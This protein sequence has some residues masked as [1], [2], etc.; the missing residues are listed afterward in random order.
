ML[1]GFEWELR[2]FNA[3]TERVW[4]FHT[5]R[6]SLDYF[7]NSKNFVSISDNLNQEQ[8]MT[9]TTTTDDRGWHGGRKPLLFCPC[10]QK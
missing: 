5:Y 8:Q 3:I 2:H 7:R 6:K 4:Q 10:V 1:V 9:T